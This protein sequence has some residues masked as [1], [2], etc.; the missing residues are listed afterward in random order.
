MTVN[1]KKTP[2]KIEMELKFVSTTYIVTEYFVSKGST[3]FE[4]S[5]VC[6]TMINENTKSASTSMLKRVW[7]VCLR[8]F[9]KSPA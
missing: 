3:V 8:S 5:A 1:A 7:E 9:G 4:K 6:M 2:P